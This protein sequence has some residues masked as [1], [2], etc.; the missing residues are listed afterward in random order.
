MYECVSIYIRRRERKAK[1][2]HPISPAPVFLAKLLDHQAPPPLGMSRVRLP[3]LAPRSRCPHSPVR[4]MSLCHPL[5]PSQARHAFSTRVRRWRP[6]HLT[7]AQPHPEPTGQSI[8]MFIFPLKP[9]P[10][11][12][13]PP[14]LLYAVQRS[15][16]PFPTCSSRRRGACAR[17]STRADL[18]PPSP[19]IV[20]K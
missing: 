19:I 4:S 13:M 18:V 12:P 14:P 2:T 5:T 15:S 20:S 8:A 3:S 6:H 17:S 7:N 9:E 10:P 11:S 1:Y 16:P